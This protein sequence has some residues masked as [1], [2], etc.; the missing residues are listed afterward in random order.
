[1]A[2]AM[3]P[4]PFGTAGNHQPIDEPRSS[5]GTSKRLRRALWLSEITVCLCRGEGW[6]Q[7]HSAM[8]PV[9]ELVIS[10]EY[11]SGGSRCS[12]WFLL[13]PAPSTGCRQPQTGTVP[14]F[15]VFVLRVVGASGA[16]C[17]LPISNFLIFVWIPGTRTRQRNRNLQRH[18]DPSTSELWPSNCGLS[19]AS[20]DRPIGRRSGD[21]PWLASKLCTRY[22]RWIPRWSLAFAWPIQG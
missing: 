13:P 6:Q 8:L 17:A 11:F 15:F 4:L 3:S 10:P 19:L 16:S 18:R 14:P 22:G 20:R 12:L 5:R 2:A 1:M 9:A 21:C 7:N